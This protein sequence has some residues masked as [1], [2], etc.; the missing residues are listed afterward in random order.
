MHPIPTSS[1]LGTALAATDYDGAVA[2]AMECAVEKRRELLAVLREKL[3]ARFPRLQIVATL[4]PPFGEW[5]AEDDARILDEIEKSG[6]DFVWIGLGCPKQERWMSAHA[7]ELRAVMLG[8]GAAFDFHAGRLRQ[9]PGGLQ[10]IGLEWL[11]RMAMEPRR[12]AKRYVRHNPRFAAMALRE[13]AMRRGAQ[14]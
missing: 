13:L 10:G 2:H 1:V 12:L 6:A 11:C 7:G 4:S 14:G 9:A 8:V 5:S 3:L